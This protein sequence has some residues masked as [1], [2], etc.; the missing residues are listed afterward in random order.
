ML[1]VFEVQTIYIKTILFTIK[2]KNFYTKKLYDYIWYHDIISTNSTK[3]LDTQKEENMV[4]DMHVHPALFADICKEKAR[5]NLR[6]D[7]MGYHLMSPLPLEVLDKQNAFAGI[8]KM[9]LL[10]LDHSTRCA[11]RVLITNEEVA[12]L[13]A[14]RPDVFIGFASVDP[15]RSDALEVLEKAF[16]EQKL[17]G[18]KLNPAKQRFYPDDPRLAPIYDLC[19]RYNRPIVFHA[20]LSWEPDTLTKYAHPLRFE[21]VAQRWPQLRI[22]LAHFAWPWARETAML[23]IKY[24]NVYTDTAMMYMDSAEQF[25]DHLFKEEMGQYWLEHNFPNQ[26]MFGSNAPR[27]RPVRIKRGLDSVA[28]SEDVRRQVYGENA[29][30]FL[31]LGGKQI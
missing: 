7:E 12:Q 2:N 25:F 28:M 29:L 16:G 24:P 3:F 27:F 5:L 11:G 10:P 23:M 15:F 19:A 26:V 14:L 18:L 31:G 8:D 22:C 17:A 4:I 20:G 6:C 13:V 21:E 9:A 30:R 1:F